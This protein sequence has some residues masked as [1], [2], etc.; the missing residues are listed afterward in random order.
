[1]EYDCPRTTLQ[2]A[3]A[4]I[5]D[6][7]RTITYYKGV[8]GAPTVECNRNRTENPDETS[9]RCPSHARSRRNTS[10]AS[11][12]SRRP[13][14]TFPTEPKATVR[15][16]SDR[17]PADQVTQGPRRLANRIDHL[18]GSAA[19]TD[20]PDQRS[21]VGQVEEVRRHRDT[22]RTK[23]RGRRGLG[24][25][26][27]VRQVGESEAEGRQGLSTYR[28]VRAVAGW[29]ASHSATWSSTF[30]RWLTA[31]FSSCVNSAIVRSS[32]GRK[33]IGS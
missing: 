33:K 2:S 17:I 13:N 9:C 11:G 19:W 10:P 28:L 29:P 8:G 20:E 12:R 27:R 32:C 21:N 31:S 15:L 26:Y 25:S 16:D 18:A 14:G 4:T 5:A 24:R 3:L 6:K 22:D 30:P 7:P 23:L 1:M